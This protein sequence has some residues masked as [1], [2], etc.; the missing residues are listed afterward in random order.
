MAANIGGICAHL[1][2]R[3][4]YNE[5]RM[6]LYNDP[7][8]EGGEKFLRRFIKN[9]FLKDRSDGGTIGRLEII[10]PEDQ[11][12]AHAILDS[13]GLTQAECE[14][15]KSSILFK[16][17]SEPSQSPQQ[18]AATS[19]NAAPPTDVKEAK[20]MNLHY[21]RRSP[22]EWM[23]AWQAL[24]EQARGR[25]PNAGRRPIDHAKRPVGGGDD[26]MPG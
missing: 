25:A 22:D 15:K 4:E 21:D 23:R 9:H 24:D 2:R 12:K 26:F 20:G 1:V 7:I 10:M 18:P 16:G 14:R 19:E 3:I 5:T 8:A 6:M 13:L 17:G 11:E